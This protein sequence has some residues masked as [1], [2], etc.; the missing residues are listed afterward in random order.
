MTFLL[1]AAGGF[2]GAICRY[3]ITL[4][5]ADKTNRHF[6]MGT[7]LVNL[8][9][10]FL[11]GLVVGSSMNGGFYAFSAI[12]FLGGFTT[13]STL[14]VELVE[15][16]KSG[17]YKAFFLYLSCTYLGGICTAFIGMLLMVAFIK[18]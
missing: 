17:K 4:F 14:S 7:F 9:G 5:F 12:G 15:L 8:F 16:F 11:L 10:S 1:V 2:L 3:A 13:F 18:M 6:P